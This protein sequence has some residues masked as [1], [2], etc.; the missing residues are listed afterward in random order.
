[1]E[2]RW[3]YKNKPME[4]KLVK[5]RMTRLGRK[6]RPFY[7][8]I[9]IDSRKRRDGMFIE[10]IGHYDPYAKTEETK[11]MIND[12]VALKWLMEGAQPSD[13]VKNIFSQFGIMLKYD[14]KKRFKRE[15]VG[16]KY[17]VVKDAEGNFVRMFTDEEIEKAYQEFLAAKEA[18]KTKKANAAT[19]GTKLSKKAKA[20]MEEEKKAA[21]EPKSEEGAE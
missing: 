1:M 6:K 11:Y 19:S 20:K 12:E 18:K 9:A 21:A 8:I 4:E 15:K 3:Q 5:L 17:K 14:M 7:R 13:T 2:T 10:R 16:E